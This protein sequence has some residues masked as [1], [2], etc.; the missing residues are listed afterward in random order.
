[1]EQFAIYPSEAWK[2]A[3]KPCRAVN[4]AGTD[5]ISSGSTIDSTGKVKSPPKPI[6]SC[7]SSLVITAQGSAS[8]P[9]PAVVGIATMGSAPA[10]GRPLPLPAFT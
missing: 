4:F 9:V 3:S 2:K 5:T 6:F 7:R 10:T 8:V 1:M